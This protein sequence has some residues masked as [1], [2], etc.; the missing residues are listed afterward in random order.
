MVSYNSQTTKGS[1]KIQ[2]ETD[3]WECYREVEDVIRTWIDRSNK[4]TEQKIITSFDDLVKSMK[5]K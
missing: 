3:N 5:S 4:D 2:F 1:Y